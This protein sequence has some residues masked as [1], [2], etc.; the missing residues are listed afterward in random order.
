MA[1]LFLLEIVVIDHDIDLFLFD[2][3]DIIFKGTRQEEVIAIGKSDI[4]G[5]GGQNAFVAA[6]RGS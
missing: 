3:A 5:T 4:R 1:V 2:G 6:S